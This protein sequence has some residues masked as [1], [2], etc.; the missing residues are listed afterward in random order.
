MSARTPTLFRPHPSD[1]ELAY[2]AGII[3]GEGCIYVPKADAKYR[4]PQVVVSNTDLELLAWVQ[5]RFGGYLAKASGRAPMNRERTKDCYTVR[6]G[7]AQMIAVLLKPL[8]PYLVIK[9]GKAEAAIVRARELKQN[10]LA[11]SR[12]AGSRPRF[13]IAKDQERLAL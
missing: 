2:F 13:T 5:A 11:G 6:W 12:K 9:R 4:S 8:L 10:Q 3:D 7:G 1:T